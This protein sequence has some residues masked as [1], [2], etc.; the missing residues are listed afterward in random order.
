MP[1]IRLNIIA[2]GQ[3]EERFVKDILSNHLSV[4]NV[5]AF[6]RCVE[7]RRK[8]RIN[9]I[10]RGGLFNYEKAKKDIANWLKQDKNN[11]A[12]FTTM[13]D[14]YALPDNF[15]GYEQAQKITDVYEKVKYLESALFEDIDET[16]FIPY[17]QLH[18]FEALIF[19]NPDLISMEYLEHNT[20]I[21]NLK[22][23]LIE[24]DN[25]P[26]M[27]NDNPDT[28]PSKRI[29]KE[30]PEYDKVNSGAIIL[31]EIGIEHLKSKCKHFNE[32]I[33]KLE[34]LAD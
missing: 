20:Q 14:L 28:A 19:S 30:I 5:G 32:W 33:E 24:F 8:K 23:V 6:V 7:T 27:I 15:P 18:E 21:Q 9:K 4:Y 1:Y 31:K 11:D 29:L 16:R 2:E 13:F 22:N 12:R 10:Y 3:S 34:K 25:N 26:E 17:I